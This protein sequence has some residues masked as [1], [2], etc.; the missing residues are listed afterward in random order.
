MKKIKKLLNKYKTIIIVGLIVAVVIHFSLFTKNILTADVLLNTG[1]YSGYSWEISLGRF[2]LY[3]VGLLKGFLVMG[4]LEIIISMVLMVFS[5]ILIIDLFNIN[6]KSLQI[7]CTI[8]MMVSPILSSMFLFHYCT[9]AYSLAFFTSVLAI[10]LF[11]NCKRVLG[12]YITPILLIVTSLSMYQAYLAVPLTFLLLYFL[13]KILEKKFQWKDFFKAFG[14]VLVASFL[15][16]ILM[17]ITLFIFNVDL[18]SYRGA[19][20]VG[21]K[22]L[23]DI[24]SRII[25]AYQSFYQFY[26]TDSIIQTGNLGIVYLNI[27]LLLLVVVGAIYQLVKRKIKWQHS[28]LFI[29]L[30]LLLPLMINVIVIIFPDTMLQLLMSFGYLFI[31]FFLCYIVDNSKFLTIVT[32]FLFGLFIR[33]YVIQ[34]N[35]TYS[36]LS[37]TYQKTYQIGLDLKDKINELGYNKEVMIAGNLDNNSYYNQKYATEIMRF[38][39]YTYGFVADYSLFWDEYTNI[40]NGWSRFMEQFVGTTI[41]FVDNDT[42]QKILESDEYKDMKTYPDCDSIKLIDDVITI[43]LAK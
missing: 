39:D 14:I 18:S 7:G 23:L 10:Y 21:L 19:N 6:K 16:F 32:I 28:L 15:Y 26:F 29:G 13:I 35:A 3:V 25:L 4:Q 43:K 22:M 40:K 33:G 1:F 36:L 34:D 9:L 24:P 42:Y 5:T 2:G 38:K 20:E 37:L 11:F 31:F 27:I 8:L 41:H 30:L 17:K 12:K